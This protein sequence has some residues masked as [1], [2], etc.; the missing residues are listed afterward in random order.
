MLILD[1]CCR[2][3]HPSLYAYRP[4]YIDVR[5]VAHEDRELTVCTVLTEAQILS[6]CR[7]DSRLTV[8]LE[9]RARAVKSG[10][11]TS[12]RYKAQTLASMSTVGLV[13]TFR[14]APSEDGDEL[15]VERCWSVMLSFLLFH[16]AK[17]IDHIFLYA[18]A[19]DHSD[20]VY[21]GQCVVS[22]SRGCTSES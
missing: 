18:D 2:R 17:G 14:F 5:P 3:T 22:F 9:P 1:A 4:V 11:S 21:I 8:A 19:D 13:T 6:T 12:P 7:T 10:Q 15:S 20:D 16:L